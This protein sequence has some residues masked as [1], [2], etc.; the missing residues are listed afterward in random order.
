[1]NT[2]EFIAAQRTD[3]GVPHTFSCRATGAAESRMVWCSSRRWR[4]CFPGGRVGFAQSDR[5]PTAELTT[6]AI[7]M[8]AAVRGGYINRYLDRHLGTTKTK[9]ATD[10][11]D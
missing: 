3:H 8:A 1:M 9:G 7:N 11:G 4:T 5:Y 6:T 2:A 10:S